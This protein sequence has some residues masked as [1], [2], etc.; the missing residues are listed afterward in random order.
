MKD[1]GIDLTE[2]IQQIK[3]GSCGYDGGMKAYKEY[4]E[5]MD[6][7]FVKHALLHE[8]NAVLKR[9]KELLGFSSQRSSERLW[10]F[11][12]SLFLITFITFILFGMQP[13]IDQNTTLDLQAK[14]QQLELE[15]L[16]YER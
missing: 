2:P 6:E 11:V 9:E 7:I 15:R 12:I 3:C 16:K 1:S 10:S 14:Q 5:K 8:E 13:C 4:T